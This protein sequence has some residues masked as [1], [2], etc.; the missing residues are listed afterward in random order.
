MAVEQGLEYA[1]LSNRLNLRSK[2]TYP[3]SQLLQR[4]GRW[5]EK[6]EWSCFSSWCVPDDGLLP[7][8]SIFDI[9][10]T[11]LPE[12]VLSL[13][14]HTCCTGETA[15]CRGESK[16]RILSA[17]IR[18]YNLS[19][20]RYS[21]ILSLFVFLFLSN[22][23]N[24]DKLGIFYN[25]EKWPMASWMIPLLISFVWGTLVHLFIARITLIAEGIM[26]IPG[27]GVQ[28]Y[29]IYGNGNQYSTFYESKLLTDVLI[30]EGVQNCSAYYYLSLITNKEEIILLLQ[31]SRP[32]LFY[33]Q[34]LLRQIKF[35]LLKSH[36]E[37]VA[38]GKG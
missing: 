19:Q 7:I 10:F 6:G 36:S 34:L 5:F 28:L 33:L 9:F 11:F 32:R 13:P 35:N 3:D 4:L 29:Q 31:N 21:S 25:V 16:K 15:S 8:D 27:L 12:N 17:V 1:R 38:D 24:H 30:C 37:F 23:W 22:P 20:L 18:H 14:K 2:G 26:V